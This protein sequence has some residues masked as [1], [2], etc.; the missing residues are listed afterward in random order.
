MD[1]TAKN[2]MVS[3]DKFTDPILPKAGAPAVSQPKTVLHLM[4]VVLP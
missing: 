2:P 3:A 1:W 4:P